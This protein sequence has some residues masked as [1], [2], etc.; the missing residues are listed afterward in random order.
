MWY[1]ALCI[2]FTS[3]FVLQFTVYFESTLTLVP[4]LYL[5]SISYALMNHMQNIN[6][7]TTVEC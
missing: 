1:V 3:T 5:N 4:C 7:G 6:L 2:L